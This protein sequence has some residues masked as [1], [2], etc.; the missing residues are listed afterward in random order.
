MICWI[1]SS[2]SPPEDLQIALHS[3]PVIRRRFRKF[4]FEASIPK[5][6]I[7]KFSDGSRKSSSKFKFNSDQLVLK[8]ERVRPSREETGAGRES[9]VRAPSKITDLFFFR[10]LGKQTFNQSPSLT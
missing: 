5:V 2:V 3:S 8:T 1:S 9:C 7:L 10:H 6:W 4:S